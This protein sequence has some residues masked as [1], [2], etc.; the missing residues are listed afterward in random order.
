MKHAFM[1]TLTNCPLHPL[2]FIEYIW[3][4]LACRRHKIWHSRE[5][6]YRHSLVKI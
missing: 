4:Y 5:N 2:G 6:K 1:F 3:E